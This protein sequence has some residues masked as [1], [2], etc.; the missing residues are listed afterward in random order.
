MLLR[1]NLPV[2]LGAKSLPDR[3]GLRGSLA[4][5]GKAVVATAGEWLVTFEATAATCCL[6]AVMVAAFA[7]VLGLGL[8]FAEFVAVRLGLFLGGDGSTK[9]RL[10]I[11]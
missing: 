7:A 10:L 6:V 3:N 1:L 11:S 8:A 5:S 9:F 2:P 4:G